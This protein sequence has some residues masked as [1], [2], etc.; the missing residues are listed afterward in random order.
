MDQWLMS[1][2]AENNDA[3]EVGNTEIVPI[4]CPKCNTVIR[5]TKRY[6]RVLNLRAMDIEKVNFPQNF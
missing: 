1:K 3:S 4:I 6:M 5:R 2:V